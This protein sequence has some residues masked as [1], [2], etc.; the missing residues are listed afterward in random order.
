MSAWL[1]AHIDKSVYIISHTV[2]YSRRSCA[3]NSSCHRYS[4]YWVIV[5]VIANL[6]WIPRSLIKV[7]K[8]H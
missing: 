7:Y 5:I 2:L 3:H 8:K 6:T 4:E 1:H